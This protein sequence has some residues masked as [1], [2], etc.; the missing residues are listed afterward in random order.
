MRAAQIDVPVTVLWTTPQ[1]PRGIDRLVTDDAPDHG[2]W[3]ASMDV[4]ARTEDSR[5]GLDGR[6]HTQLLG[7]EPVLVL[8]A[9]SAPVGWTEVIAQWQPHHGDERGYRGWLR[10]AHL[11]PGSASSPLDAPPPVPVDRTTEPPSTHP[12]RA[13]QPLHSPLDLALHPALHLARR[14]LGIRYLWGGM[15]PDAVDCSGLVHYVWRQLGV[16][17]PRDADDQC[18]AAASIPLAD[19]QPG[20][21]YFF[22]DPDRP[23]HHV[24]IVV[25]AD[26]MLHAPMTGQSVVEEALSP[27]RRDT[28]ISAG[29]FPLSP[30]QSRP[31][32]GP[33]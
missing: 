14:F 12:E 11:R 8:D 26:V 21:L 23:V 6:I 5:S 24:G 9:V 16:V 15:G 2:G 28:L 29:R 17:I 22:A 19:V 3:L 4:A 13:T 25:T 20:D 10:S 7:D 1:A 32:Q 30:V 27:A 33:A 31:L 18:A